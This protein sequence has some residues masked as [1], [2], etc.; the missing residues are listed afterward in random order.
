MQDNEVTDTSR[1]TRARDHHND[2]SSL[3]LVY[4]LLFRL[5]LVVVDKVDWFSFSLS[6]FFSDFVVLLSLFIFFLSFS[7]IP[8]YFIPSIYVC[9]FVAERTAIAD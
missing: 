9:I 2:F 8:L 7:S 4:H 6:L 5:D 3:L 1:L